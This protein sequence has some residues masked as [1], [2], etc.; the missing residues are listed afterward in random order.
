M[1]RTKK[2]VEGRAQE[3]KY[4]YRD[5]HR[6]CRHSAVDCRGYVFRSR[7]ARI[8]RPLNRRFWCRVTT[9]SIRTTVS[10]SG[11]LS[12]TGSRML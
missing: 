3:S 12:A 7:F 2:T 10:G 1:S 4:P 6:R 5:Q 9:G 11:L 8:L